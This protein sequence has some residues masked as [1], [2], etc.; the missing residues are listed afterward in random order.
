MRQ[1][2]D[3]ITFFLIEGDRTNERDVGSKGFSENV[4]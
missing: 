2:V 4:Q 1:D 3:N